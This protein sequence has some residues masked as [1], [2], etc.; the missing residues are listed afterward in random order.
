MK[1]NYPYLKRSLEEKIVKLFSAFPVVVIAGGRQV[2]KSTILEHLFPKIPRVIFDPEV[3]V[4]NANAQPELFLNNRRPP[5]VLDEIQYAK[6]IV[7]GIKRRLDND[8]SPGQYLI[9]GSQQ[10]QVMKLL[11]ESLAGRAIFIDLDSLS[12]LEI[13]ESENESWLSYWL[14]NESIDVNRCNLLLKDRTLYEQL[15]RGFL[16]EPQFI[17]SEF[18]PDYFKSFERTYIQKDVRSISDVEDVTLFSRFYRLCATLS[19]QEINYNQIGRDIDVTPQT[20][21][22]W[23]DVLRATFQWF[24]LPAWSGNLIK[25]ISQ[26]PKGYIADTGL[27]CFALAISDFSVLGSHPILGSLFETASVLEIKKLSQ[28]LPAQPNLYHW[29]LHSGSEVDLIIEWNGKL[30][31]IEIKA[32]TSITKKDASGIMAFKKSRSKL[33][34]GKGLIVAPVTTPYS[35]TE[36]VTVLPWNCSVSI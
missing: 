18:V 32:K 9:T 21:S 29:R 6:N 5:I 22:R 34:I 36:D 35:L 28:L 17:K 8:R 7:P 31:P 27:L 13:Y 4:E 20:A 26:K 3:D 25:K 1:S 33:P 11:S 14:K 10:W 30:F 16:P 19:A 12:L 23:L 2:G 15:W 24:E